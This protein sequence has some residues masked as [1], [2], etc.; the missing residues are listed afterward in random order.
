MPTLLMKNKFRD[1]PGSPMVKTS[2]FHC[3][4]WGFHPWWVNLHGQKK[5]K[6]KKE[7]RKKKSHI[8]KKKIISSSDMTK[9]GNGR[10]LNKIKD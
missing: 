1:F 4:R 9:T 3:R 6:R 10:A 7:K 2:H 5:K 8:K